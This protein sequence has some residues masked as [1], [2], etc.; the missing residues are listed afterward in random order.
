MFVFKKNLF[1]SVA[2]FLHFRK[3]FCFEKKITVTVHFSINI[4][5]TFTMIIG[6]KNLGSLKFDFRQ[7]DF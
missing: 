2:F 3:R 6:K 5:K 4:V 1:F 7:F